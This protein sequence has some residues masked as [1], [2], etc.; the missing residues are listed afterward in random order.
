MCDTRVLAAASI[1]KREV[2]G[3]DASMS[4]STKGRPIVE[5]ASPVTTDSALR[6]GPDHRALHH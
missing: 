2:Q 6:R 5:R 1:R 3:M 4:K